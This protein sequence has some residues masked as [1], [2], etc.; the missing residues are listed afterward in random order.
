MLGLTQLGVVHTAISL[1]A[2]AAGIVAFARYQEIAVR[3][4]LA[5]S[6]SRQRRSPA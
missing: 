1:V 6:T 2:V 4:P 5:F 3:T